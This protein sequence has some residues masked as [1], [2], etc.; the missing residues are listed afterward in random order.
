[1]N[2]H[3][4][5]KPGSATRRNFP[6]R[7]MTATWAV[8]TV[9]KLP[10]IVES[11]KKAKIAM[12]PQPNVSIFAPHFPVRYT[13]TRHLPDRYRLACVHTEVV[14]GGDFPDARRSGVDGGHL[15]NSSKVLNGSKAR[16]RGTTGSRI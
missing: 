11:T 4:P 2:G 12:T 7:V 15:L 13:L 8:L 10:R 16:I 1:M 5:F 14:V 9:K 6:N 3:F